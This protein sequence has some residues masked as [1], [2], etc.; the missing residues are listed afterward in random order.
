MAKTG[1]RGI[2]LMFTDSKDG[3]GL[4][5]AE[6]GCRYTIEKAFTRAITNYDKSV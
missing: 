1:C 5:H 6:R 4:G 2:S 3:A